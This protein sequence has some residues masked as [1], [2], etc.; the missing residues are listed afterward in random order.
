MQKSTV[1][2]LVLLSL[3]VSGCT[4]SAPAPSST[5]IINATIFDGSGAAKKS[6]SLRIDGD[7]IVAIEYNANLAALDREAVIDAAGMILAPG[8]ID[9]HSH[10]DTHWQQYRSM[11]GVL[12]Q[13]ITTIVRG[14]DGF[15]GLENEFEFQPLAELHT[16]LAATPAA[17]NIAS[18]SPHNSLRFAVLGDDFRRVATDSEIAAMANLLVDD[19]TAGAL[20]LA[21]GLE[22]DP[23]IY[24][25]TDEVIRLAQVAKAYNGRYASHI[26]DE[27]DGFVSALQELIKIS[28]EADIPAHISHIKVADREHWGN[29]TSIVQMLSAARSNGLQITADIY[30]YER[31]ASDFSVLFPERDL[32]SVEAAEYAFAHTG[33]PDD[34]FVAEFP[35]DPGLAGRTIAEIARLTERSTV[36][37]LLSMAQ[38][39][40]GYLRQTGR[41]GAAIIVK[42]MHENDIATLMQWDYINICSDGGHGGGHPRGYGAFPRVLGKYVRDDGVL[43]MQDAIRKMTALTA[44]TLGI[45]ERGR[46]EVGYFADLV[47]FDAGRVADK[48]TMED[49]TATAVGIEKV[50]VNGKLAFD[51][52]APTGT[53]AGQVVTRAAM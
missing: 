39:A 29:G 27:D 21:T 45:A 22:Y 42:G 5:L 24:S 26:R 47:L 36:Q 17:V 13:G 34:I 15:V 52:D 49:S 23:G 30:P 38:T 14:A 12:S 40:D 46:I 11:P 2:M 20:G 48:A 9:S 51:G 25:D 19:M 53:Y 37:T 8:F 33:A 7:R 32:A 10:H 28:A 4:D 31:W 43:E 3:L 41:S 18:F 35:V 50:W 44:E 1:V 6:G 16:Q